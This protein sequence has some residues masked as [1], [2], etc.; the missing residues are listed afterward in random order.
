[1]RFSGGLR[2]KPALA[3]L[4]LAGLG[5]VFL[6]ALNEKRCGVVVERSTGTMC[7]HA[8]QQLIECCRNRRLPTLFE[9]ACEAVSLELSA[10]WIE[11]FIDAVGK[12]QEP[13]S[14][15]ELYF[16]N[17]TGIMGE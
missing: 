7:M 13:I 16:L 10:V 9:I 4:A 8:L 2:W 15:A 12:S 3:A 5:C 11:H 1:M 6:F 17:F 14:R